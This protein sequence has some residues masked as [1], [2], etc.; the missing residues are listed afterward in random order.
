MKGKPCGAGGLW[1][2]GTAH[3]PAVPMVDTAAVLH[4]VQHQVPPQG[5]HGVAVPLAGMGKGGPRMNQVWQREITNAWG[6][7]RGQW[8]G[9]G[10]GR[11]WGL[12][13]FSGA[14]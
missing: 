14:G 10:S 9:A 1:P 12:R 13:L 11:P 7:K 3:L 8:L 6:Q 2:V 5:L 4:A